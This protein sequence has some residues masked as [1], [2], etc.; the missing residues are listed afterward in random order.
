M[1]W[2][3]TLLRPPRERA[4]RTRLRAPTHAR[5]P[6]QTF[7]PIQQHSRTPGGEQQPIVPHEDPGDQESVGYNLA[8]QSDEGPSERRPQSHAERRRAEELNQRIARDC[9][10]QSFKTLR[11]QEQLSSNFKQQL[12]CSQSQLLAALHQ[13]WC[14]ICGLPACQSSQADHVVPVW[15]ISQHYFLELQVPIFKCH[16]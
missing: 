1:P 15:F 7:Q 14:S 5:R 8:G 13:A 16:G 10:L 4:P 6:V 3:F 12:D 9:L 11:C 2:D